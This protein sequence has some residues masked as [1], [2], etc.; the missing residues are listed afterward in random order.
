MCQ[1]LGMKNV[2]CSGNGSEEE[3]CKFKYVWKIKLGLDI[4]LTCSGI[5]C[6]YTPGTIEGSRN[7]TVNKSRFLSH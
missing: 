1:G 5:L 2:M 3:Y 7:T 4:S 6:C